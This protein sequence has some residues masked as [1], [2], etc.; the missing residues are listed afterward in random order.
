MEA[1]TITPSPEPT[2]ASTPSTPPLHTPRS[3]LITGGA[4]FIGANF[5][6][7]VAANHPNARMTVLDA[8]TYAGNRASLN[9]VAPDRL[10]FVHGDICERTLVERL[11]HEQNIDT[12]VHF[13]A[14]S[15]STTSPPTRCTAI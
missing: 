9:G 5:V 8:L 7:W 11:L 4:G 6:H 13:A 14:T 3:L 10:A 2:A 1:M 15:D 12:I